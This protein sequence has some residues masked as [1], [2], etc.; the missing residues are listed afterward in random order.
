MRSVCKCRRST[1]N[2]QRTTYAHTVA[3]LELIYQIVAKCH[4]DRSRQ[5]HLTTDLQPHLPKWRSFG[6]LLDR[7]RLEVHILRIAK[8]ELESLLYRSRSERESTFIVGQR[9]HGTGRSDV[10]CSREHVHIVFVVELDTALRTVVHTTKDLGS[11]R[12]RTI[13]LG[14]TRDVLV[15]IPSTQTSLVKSS[16]CSWRG[17]TR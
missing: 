16:V 17:L 14:R 8:F 10:I 4:I 6:H 3:R 7:D 12:R 15:T 2:T 11:K 5:L 1:G 13:T 9:D